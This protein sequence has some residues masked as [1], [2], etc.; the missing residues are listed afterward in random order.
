MGF[1]SHCQ[2]WRKFSTFLK[3]TDFSSVYM[4]EINNI[5]HILNSFSLQFSKISIVLID[6]KT[7]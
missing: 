5:E 7:Q 3:F 2:I 1:V 4:T 6:S